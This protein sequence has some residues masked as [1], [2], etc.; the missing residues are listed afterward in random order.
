MLLYHVF[1]LFIVVGVGFARVD[2]DYA[3]SE[4]EGDVGFGW[5]MEDILRRDDLII[6]SIAADNSEVDAEGT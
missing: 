3:F 4:F 2:G 5:G 6:L 1:N